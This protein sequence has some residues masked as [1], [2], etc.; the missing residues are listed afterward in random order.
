M[1]VSAIPGSL[2]PKKYVIQGYV[3][4]DGNYTNGVK[5]ST[6][7]NGGAC[8]YSR[9]L[10]INGLTFPG[11]Y[12][13]VLN[14]SGSGP[15]KVKATYNYQAVEA[16]IKEPD[17]S[18]DTLNININT[19]KLQAYKPP[20]KILNK[21]IITGQVMVNGFPQNDVEV[22]TAYGGGATTRTYTLN[23]YDAATGNNYILD[24]YFKLEVL[25]S[26]GP[27]EVIAKYGNRESTV[28]I[29]EP[30][31]ERGYDDVT[32]YI[33]ELTLQLVRTDYILDNILLIE[34]YGS[35]LNIDVN[36][37]V[38]NRVGNIPIVSSDGMPVNDSGGNENG[39]NIVTPVASTQP[40]S[41]GFIDNI[42]SSLSDLIS[43]I[44]GLFG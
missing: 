38:S 4:V 19:K 5:V 42:V 39:N 3:S 26:S 32:I 15:I 33:K 25:E 30:D 27:V 43:K 31:L 2:S 41:K 9:N 37:S 14:W 17:S 11:Y 8:C 16:W 23:E 22:S 18:G 35:I 12:A 10:N 21:Y 36:D 29:Q 7:Y 28:I 1:T 24:G 34:N 44:F 13:L 40:E 20:Q 6:D